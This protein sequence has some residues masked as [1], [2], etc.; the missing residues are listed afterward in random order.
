MTSTYISLRK[1]IAEHGVV[2]LLGAVV[3]GPKGR[4]VLR[5]VRPPD[6]PSDSAIRCYA[7]GVGEVWLN[8]DTHEVLSSVAVARV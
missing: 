3:F 8:M 4:L 2:G 7:E 5:D 6:G 1:C